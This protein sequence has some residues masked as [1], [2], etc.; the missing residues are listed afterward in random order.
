MDRRKSKI[1]EGFQEL[2]KRANGLEYDTLVPAIVKKVSSDNECT[3]EIEDLEVHDVRLQTIK[4]GSNESIIVVPE[5]GSWVILGGIESTEEYLVL[6]VQRA[7]KVLANIQGGDH[8]IDADG[9]R[10]KKGTTEV[11]V[12][13]AG[14]SVK[15][16]A[17][18]LKSELDALIDAIMAITV[19][20]AVG[21]SSVPVNIASFASIKVKLGQL[22]K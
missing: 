19:T 2:A 16:G 14:V 21:V 9:F 20:T 7:E 11:S 1:A 4:T 8:V 13:S 10:W 18:S 22:L 15:R 6:S 12:E 17:V 5:V 3:C